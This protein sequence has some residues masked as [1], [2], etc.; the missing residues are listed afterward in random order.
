MIAS[1]FMYK[2]T[3]LDA[4]HA[5]YWQLIRQFLAQVGIDS[6]NTLSQDA[7][8]FSVWQHPDLVLAQTCGMPYRTKL[9]GHVSLIGTPDFGISGCPAGYYRSAFVVRTDDPRQNIADFRDARF[10]YNERDS[11]SGYAAAYTH[12]RPLGF[13]FDN[14]RQSG[15]H[16][17]SA[18]AVA[19]ARAD[20]AALDAVSWRPIRRYETFAPELR[21][22]EWTAPT[23]GLP[24][25]AAK[26]ANRHETFAAIARAIAALEPADQ[27]ALGL[28]SLVAIP[29][30][31]Y[32]AIANPPK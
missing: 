5:R 9:H 24:Y 18:R 8:P 3:E 19:N 7:E 29:P 6:P 20:I 23:P 25:I 27:Q 2:R 26:T 17:Q 1:L 32:L 30:E 21:V 12:L 31:T 28:K 4:A 14:T 15:A 13:W 10:T 22:L 16:L 11:Q